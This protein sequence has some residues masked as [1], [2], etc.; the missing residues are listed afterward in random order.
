[1]GGLTETPEQTMDRLEKESRVDG[2]N[3]TIYGCGCIVLWPN[4]EMFFDNVFRFRCDCPLHRRLK[5]ES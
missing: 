4:N 5:K 3:A 2:V 1:M